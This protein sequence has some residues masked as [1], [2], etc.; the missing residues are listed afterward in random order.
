MYYPL[1]KIT[2]NLYTSGNEFSNKETK[3]S[4]KGYYFSTYDGKFF[5]EKTPLSSS[6][7]LIKYVA[8]NQAPTLASMKYVDAVGSPSQA[9]STAHYTPIPSDADYTNG[10]IIRYII[11]R[12]NGDT[13][14][15][16]EVSREDYNALKNDPLYIQTSFTWLIKGKLEPTYMGSSIVVPGVLEYNFKAI[17]TTERTIP[18]VSLILRNLAQFHK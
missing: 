12:V 10:Y 2:P 5:T 15:I 11:R 18:G 7:E 3:Q 4:Y 14:T 17:Q 16:R 13:S 8:K 6:V 1:A 9:S